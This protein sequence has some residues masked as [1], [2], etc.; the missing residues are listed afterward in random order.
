MTYSP[1]ALK[2]IHGASHDALSRLLEHCRDFSPED[3][4]REH[5]GFGYPSVRLQIHHVLGAERYWLGVLEG[6]VDPDNPEGVDRSIDSLEAWR[7]SI[8]EHTNEYLRAATDAEL[9]EPRPCRMWD[10]STKDLVP[11]RV[12]LRTLTHFFDH[13]GQIA[14]MCRSLGRP[15]PAGLD[16]PIL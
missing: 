2:T 9:N 14:A 15:I 4:G 6:T 13:R 11:A 10:D 7:R 12:V 16:F 8:E 5:D 1:A 3:L